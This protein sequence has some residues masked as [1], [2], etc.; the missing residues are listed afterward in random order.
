MY[1]TLT[2]FY[3]IW[4]CRMLC[5]Q[6]QGNIPL[7]EHP[8]ELLVYG[9]G[10]EGCLDEY[11]VNLLDTSMGEVCS[12]FVEDGG[13]VN[14]SIQ[15]AMTRM[16][17]WEYPE[18]NHGSSTSTDPPSTPTPPSTCVH[19]PVLISR[20]YVVNSTQ[21]TFTVPLP[22]CLYSNVRGNKRHMLVVYRMNNFTV[23]S[24]VLTIEINSSQYSIG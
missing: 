4:L 23:E 1:S 14:L 5:I 10:G 6:V 11:G 20:E 21:H 16:A 18:N 24:F 13:C 17:C 12:V 9:L 19:S 2:A 7:V 8:V 3:Q 22:L 15:K